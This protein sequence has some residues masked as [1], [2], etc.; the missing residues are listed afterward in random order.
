MFTGKA[1]VTQYIAVTATDVTLEKQNNG[2]HF[3][4]KNNSCDAINLFKVA[5]NLAI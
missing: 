5:V 3:A 4:E 1:P 2:T